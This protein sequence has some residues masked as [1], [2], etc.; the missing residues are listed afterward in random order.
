MIRRRIWLILI[1]FVLFSAGSV[2]GTNIWLSKAPQYTAEALLL[3]ES[4][5]IPDELAASTVRTGAGEQLE[6]ILHNGQYLLDVINDILDLS[7]IEAGKMEVEVTE[8][9]R[10]RP[11][12]T[13]TSHPSTYSEWTT[14]PSRQPSSP[15]SPCCSSCS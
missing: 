7:K 13:K 9:I 1:C 6:I 15:S 11:I 14:T 12:R 5:Q 2:V 3:V 4:P 10:T 8:T